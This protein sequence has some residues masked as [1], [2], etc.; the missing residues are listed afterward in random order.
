MSRSI[1][2]RALAPD[3]ASRRPQGFEPQNGLSVRPRLA[4]SVAPNGS[5]AHSHPAAISIGHLHES[6]LL[7]IPRQEVEGIALRVVMN[8]SF[9]HTTGLPLFGGVHGAR[10][11][12][13][14]VAGS[15]V[16]GAGSETQGSCP[17]RSPYGSVL[18][19]PLTLRHRNSPEASRPS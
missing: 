19:L 15:A 17:L 6:L 13:R 18:E 12:V 8:C 16:A 5:P 4:V 7:Y 3:R 1:P 2:R 10:H 14:I 9:T 11:R